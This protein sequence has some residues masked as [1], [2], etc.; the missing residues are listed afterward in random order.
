MTRLFSSRLI[1]CGLL[2]LNSCDGNDAA[3]PA[4]KPVPPPDIYFGADLSYVNQIVDHGGTFT[5]GGVPKDPF[6]IFSDNGSNLVR[7][8]LW[9]TPTWTKEVYGD[10]GTQNYSDRKDVERAIASAKSNGMEVLLDFHYSD[11]WADPGK[12]YIP[13]AW[14]EITNI[15]TLRDS[16][17][18]YTY[19]TLQYLSDRNL[20]PELVQLGNEINCGLLYSEA[21][22]SFP[23]AEVCNNEWANA[24]RIL[25]AAIDAVRDVTESSTVK[26]KI[27]LHVAD[28]K[29]VEWWF[30]N[31]RSQGKVTDFDIIGFS[32]YP[33]WHTTVPLNQI[34]ESISAFK[35]RYA[36]DVMILET[37]YPWTT[38][39]DDS[40]NN[41]FGALA[42]LSGYPF[43]EQGQYDL[44]TKLTQ[45]VIDGG[46]TGIVYWEPAWIS[47]PI[48]DLW[49]TGSAWE[50]CA[51]FDFSGEKIKG[52]EYPKFA[53]K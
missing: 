45:E 22:E 33:L 47:A 32:Y 15:Q 8:R 3:D 17:Y 13:A 34:S 39:S 24:G 21:P 1:L 52:M 4:I 50:N 6:V 2:L 37:A 26:T 46:G 23:T 29:N 36:K 19:A 49:G 16:V 12:Q 14:T 5:E 53:Y 48:K 42:P 11:T 30:D 51:L 31:I 10:E 35:S 18:N 20:L 43:T 41:H 27:L 25:N 44:L 9:H 7:L 40:Y 38:Q 28:P